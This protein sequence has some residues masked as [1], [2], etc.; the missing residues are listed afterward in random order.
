[1]ALG[2][3]KPGQGYWMRVMT[4]CLIGVLALASAGWIASQMGL[5]ADKLPRAAY[6]MNVTVSG[7][8]PMPGMNVDLIGP[9]EGAG[10]SGA[11]GVIGSATV[12]EYQ[13]DDRVLRVT[14]P[15]VVEGR[16]VQ[17]TTAVRAT[18][19]AGEFAGSVRRGITSQHKVEPALLQGGAAGLVILLGAVLALWFAG[20]RP[21]TVDFLIATDSEMKRVNWST[22]REIRGSTYVV[23]G[24]C[25]LLAGCLLV[26][27]VFFKTL[28]QTIGFL[29]D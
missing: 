18:A 24:A 29:G 19:G 10:S 2:I 3:Y 12:L 8:A 7:G 27:D 1:M 16:D 13:A 5:V 17:E 28:F 6:L 9:A 23:I 22:P 11:T 21:A 20:M 25:F 26:F 4:A 14:P 15:K